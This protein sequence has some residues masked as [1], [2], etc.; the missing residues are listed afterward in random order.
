MAPVG[1]AP[2]LD[3]LLNQLLCHSVIERVVMA[4]GY[5]REVV[6]NYFGDRTYNRK[7][8]YAIEKEP[9]GTGGGIRNAL[10]PTRSA[11]V[12]VV[13][14]DTLFEVNIAAMVESHR[15][16]QASLTLALKP[17]RDFSRYG[18][19]RLDHPIVR[20]II[21]PTAWVLTAAITPIV[22]PTPVCCIALSKTGKSIW[23]SLLLSAIKK[24]T[25]KQA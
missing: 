21:L 15:Q 2:F 6:Q 18:T 17:V 23:A 20:R 12:L 8:I 16:R 1:G 9:L 25:L 14:G 22:S 7:I 5:K 13:N 3:I 24:A 10:A 11:E 4:V 19:V